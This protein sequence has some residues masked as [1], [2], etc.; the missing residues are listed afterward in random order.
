[1]PW[2]KTN[3]T[4]EHTKQMKSY[5]EEQQHISKEKEVK[6]HWEKQGPYPSTVFV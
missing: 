3:K 2:I 4:K 1:M 5:S 6:R